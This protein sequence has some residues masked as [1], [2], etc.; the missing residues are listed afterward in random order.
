MSKKKQWER[1]PISAPRGWLWWTAIFVLVGG[2]IV[3]YTF[4]LQ[5]HLPQSE[6]NMRTTILVSVI[7][8]GIC[9]ISALADRFID[10]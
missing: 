2:S 5:E 6:T 4:K 8:A 7:I 3:A 10:R 1:G 9:V